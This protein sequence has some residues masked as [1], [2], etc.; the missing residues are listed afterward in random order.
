M[1]VIVGLRFG[2][3]VCRAQDIKNGNLDLL[4]H[5]ARLHI[6]YFVFIAVVEVVSAVFLIRIFAEAKKG[7]VQLANRIG[8]FHYLT[9]STEI[10]LAS[11]ALI[12]ITRAI[13]YSFQRTLNASDITGQIDRFAFTLE[14][15]FPIIM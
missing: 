13:M 11:L 10:R 14:C 9:Q 6:G 12:G 1:V 5:I 15:L 3:L 2:I 8:L 4:V 7:S